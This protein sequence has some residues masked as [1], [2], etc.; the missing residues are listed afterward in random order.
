[1]RLRLLASPTVAARRDDDADRATADVRA[2]RAQ[3][4][5]GVGVAVGIVD[6][7]DERRFRRGV[8]RAAGSGQR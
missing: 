6:D 1:M 8:R 7:D 2:D 5:R 3:R 4:R